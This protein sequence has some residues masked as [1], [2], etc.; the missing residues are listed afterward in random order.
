M[1]V[2]CVQTIE[3]TNKN[4]APPNVLK[5]RNC[6]KNEVEKDFFLLKKTDRTIPRTQKTGVRK[7][8]SDAK[9][10]QLA[11]NGLSEKPREKNISPKNPKTHPNRAYN[12]ESII[13][14]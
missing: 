6:I 7:N 5:G 13:E 4:N 11:V 8:S 10:E 2:R 1:L 12:T 14:N 3:R 9:K